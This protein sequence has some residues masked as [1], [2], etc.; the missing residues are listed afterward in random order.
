MRRRWIK[1]LVLLLM[2]PAFG[3]AGTYG[4][5]RWGINA[6]KPWAIRA[7]TTVINRA[8]PGQ[9]ID[10]TS[11]WIDLEPRHERLE[12][13]ASLTVR[14]LEEGRRTFTFLLNP[15]LR[16][17]R[18]T[19]DG[20][21]ARTSRIWCAILLRCPRAVE[22]NQ[23]ITIE[24]DYEGT[25]SDNALMESWMTPDEAVLPMLSC[26]YPI[27]L[28]SFSTFACGVTVPD[29]FDVVAPESATSV[30][31]EQGRRHIAWQASRRL[32]GATLAAGRFR[33]EDHVHGSTRCRAYT[34][35]H[36]A[37]GFGRLL[38][39]VGEA[40][41]TL[42]GHYGP[43]G[44]SAISV[45]VTPHAARAFHGGNALLVVPANDLPS[46]PYGLVDIGRLVA[47]NWWG[48]PFRDDGSRHAP[49]PG[50]GWWRGWLN[51]ARGA[52]FVNAAVGMPIFDFLRRDAPRFGFPNPCAPSRS[53]RPL[54][55]RPPVSTA[56][57]S[58]GRKWPW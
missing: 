57:D 58:T 15:G 31:A 4:A 44:F 45:L 3:L 30:P 55:T 52:R 35:S 1:I 50:R 7:S 2:G 23:D 17:T 11:I 22:P 47:H 9:R 14:S 48:A 13:R 26:W 32:L 49:R 54:L 33:R 43:D 39:L 29:G 20:Q 6:R 24:I 19:V 51:T 28:K 34:S 16:V 53:C 36:D 38:N 25:M 21:P 27:D 8:L 56:I 46:P 40:H 42:S 18:A 5:F 41:N 37:P 10:S 12:A